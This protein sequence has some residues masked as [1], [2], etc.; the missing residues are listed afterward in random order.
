MTLMVGLNHKELTRALTDGG[1]FGSKEDGKETLRGILMR[2]DARSPDAARYVAKTTV[3]RETLTDTIG[4]G[5]SFVAVA[6]I[7]VSI[8]REEAD[9]ACGTIPGTV[10]LDYAKVVGEHLYGEVQQIDM[11]TFPT[12][13]IPAQRLHMITT[14][15]FHEGKSEKIMRLSAENEAYIQPIPDGSDNH[16]TLVNISSDPTSTTHLAYDGEK[17]ADHRSAVVYSTHNNVSGECKRMGPLHVI[18]GFASHRAGHLWVD[19]H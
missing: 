2:R 17:E 16:I 11:I 18:G 4:L 1:V 19:Y 12:I 15:E 8:P 5:T 13:A 14:S 3:A 9:F 7:R 10:D 6:E